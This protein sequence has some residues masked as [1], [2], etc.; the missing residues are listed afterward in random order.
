MKIASRAAF[1]IIIAFLFLTH[2]Q[3]V[4]S[5]IFAFPG[6]EGAGAMSIGGRGGAVIHVTN[7]NDSGGGSLRACMTASGPRTCI[8]DTGGTIPLVKDIVVTN[9]YLTVAGQTAPGGGIQLKWAS[10]PPGSGAFDTIEIQTHDV[11]IRGI[12]SRPGLNSSCCGEAGQADV[13]AQNVIFDHNSFEWSDDQILNTYYNATNVTYSWNIVAEPLNLAKGVGSHG[14][15]MLLGDGGTDDNGNCMSTTGTPPAN[16]N[17]GCNNQQT[18]IIKNLFSEAV[19]RN[20]RVETGPIDIVNNVVYTNNSGP[21]DGWGIYFDDDTGSGILIGLNVRSNYLKLGPA[22]VNQQSEYYVNACCGVSRAQV[23]ID[24][25]NTESGYSFGIENPNADSFNGSQLAVAGVAPT[26]LSAATAYADITSLTSTGAGASFQVQCDGTV[27]TNYDS[28]DT[29]IIDDVKNGT[30]AVVSTIGNPSYVTWPTLSAGSP[31]AWNGNN[32]PTAWVSRY[33]LGNVNS[34]S[35]DS[36]TGYT[37]LEDYLDGLAPG[38]APASNLANIYYAQTALHGNNG[39]DCYDAYAYNDPTNGFNVGSK[40]GTGGN[41]IGPGTI[42]HLCGTFTG[43][44]GQTLLTVQGNGTAGHPITVMFDPGA[45]LQAPYWAGGEFGATGGAIQV[46]NKSYITINGDVT[47]G[48]Q[49]IIKNTANGT[50]LTYHNDSAGVVIWGCN[51]CVVE[52]LQIL[53]I[54]VSTDGDS[55]GAGTALFEQGNNNITV[56]NN[57]FIYS[58]IGMNIGYGGGGSAIT[59]GTISGNTVDFGCHLIVIGDASSGSSASGVTIE[60]N[61]IGPHTQSF[62]QPN[63]GCHQDDLFLQASNEGSSISGFLIANNTIQSD[64]CW[65]RSS[66]GLNCTSPVFYS[67]E[68]NSTNFVN[69]LIQYVEPTGGLEGLINEFVYCYTDSTCDSSSSDGFYNNT[70]DWNDAGNGQSCTCAVLKVNGNGGTVSGYK[71]ENNVSTGGDNFHAAINNEVGSTIGSS[72]ATINN[73]LY[74]NYSNIGYNS[75]S[76]TTYTWTT[77]QAAGWDAAGSVSN[78]VL[79][80]SYQPGNG[81]AAIGLGANLTSLSITV[82]DSDRNGNARPASGAWTAGILN[83]TGTGGG[84]QPPAWLLSATANG[85]APPAPS[86][87]AFVANIDC[88]TSSASTVSTFATNSAGCGTQP[89]VPA[90]AAIVAFARYG[91][92]CG[93]DTFTDTAGNTFALKATNPTWTTYAGN[94]QEVFCA[95]NATA[96]SAD[97][98][99]L[100]MGTASGYAVVEMQIWTGANASNPCPNQASGATSSGTTV[101]TGTFAA[102]GSSEAVAA[103]TTANA[104]SLTFNHGTGYTAVGTD[105]SGQAAGEYQIGAGITSAS[106]SISATEAIGIISTTVSQ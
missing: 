9:P 12:R 32:L 58:A 91:S 35:V 73:N 25:G 79:S 1:V 86:S 67:G 68:I 40:W 57:S 49:G 61:Q 5:A 26:V 51:T 60:G 76:S 37:Y 72:F 15:G 100:H 94:C 17:L 44:P 70:F 14:Y 29:R 97:V 95:P 93:T 38:S 65:N 103:W 89:N 71:F 21:Y 42:V 36:S 45:V 28:V 105:N 50:G 88:G 31:C 59:S 23:Y 11:I 56:S 81:S 99:T 101:T 33:N 4:S 55:N 54:Y 64:M 92:G 104:A 30:G 41:Q 102:T 43:N 84:L 22:A 87:L 24:G 47:G 77:W 80:A 10:Q 96:N 20:P 8:F 46:I 34:A 52:N 62:N 75:P 39:A 2:L 16:V 63:Q 48:R 106:S 66:P 13:D 3:K 83:G 98:G 6:A 53:N 74:Y 90:G 78:P 27:S 7:L 19:E 85:S 69:N 18:S 82:L